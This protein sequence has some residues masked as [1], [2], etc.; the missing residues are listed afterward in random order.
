MYW[1]YFA[2]FVII[3]F[4]PTIIHGTMNL[5]EAAV[6]F[7][8]QTIGLFL[9]LVSEKKAKSN[10]FKRL[11]MQR[12]M[13]QYSRDLSN[14]YNYIGEVNRKLD[15]LKEIFLTKPIHTHKHLTNSDVFSP[16]LDAAKLFGKSKHCLIRFVDAKLYKTL[17]EIKSGKRRMFLPKDNSYL[18]EDK[19]IIETEKYIIFNSR[20]DI[21]NIVCSIIIDKN[22]SG[23][24]IEDK[25]IFRIL[26]GRALCLFT[27]SNYRIRIAKA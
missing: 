14:T 22:N 16:I 18:K 19:D 9:F 20:D 11:K 3:I 2:V 17:G 27:C 13:G 4:V 12:E 6:I 15:I 25:D 8:L 23:S 24:E 1:I 7:V 21:N 26:A 5:H 10:F